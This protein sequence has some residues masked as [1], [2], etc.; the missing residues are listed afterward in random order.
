MSVLTANSVREAEKKAVDSGIFSF[1]ELMKI[2]GEGVAKEILNRYDVKDKNMAVICGKGNNGG[3][4]FVCA[5]ALRK[6]ANVT[7]VLPFGEPQ[8]KDAKKYFSCVSDLPIKRELSEEY[9]FIVDAMFGIGLNRE[10][11][12]GCKSIIQKI[13]SSNAIKIAVDVPSGAES[14]TGRMLPLC[15]KADLTVTFIAYKPCHLLPPVSD[16]CG[17]VCVLDIGVNDFTAD[18]KIIK[19]PDIKKRRKNAHKGDFGTGVIIAGSYGMCGAAILAAKGAL[20]NG[21]GILKAVI[22]QKIYAPFTVSVPEVVCLPIE[23]FDESDKVLP[24]IQNANALL[25]GSGMGNNEQTEK[26]VELVLK[27]AICPIIIDADGIN[28]L[29][30]HIDILREVSSRIIITPHPGEMARIFNVSAADIEKRRIYYAKSLAQDL[31][32]TV[33]LKGANTIVATANGE[34][35]FNI[36]GNPGM[37]T[38]GSGDVLGGIVLSLLCRG[39]SP[40]D[41]AKGGVYLHGVAGDK[42][43][44]YFGEEGLLPSDIINNL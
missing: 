42:A 34:I 16:Y 30:S 26:A 33:A 29:S 17:E 37:A 40:E 6:I 11:D 4:G 39:F 5:A 24:F 20:R 22:N 38:G 32:I 13:N 3:D 41:A 28:V 2:A 8:T 27:N 43:K 15:V 44:L 19:S 10:I 9:D 12:D 1:E 7:L 14:D 35:N 18:Y 31:Q 23:N 21:I 25:I 36:T